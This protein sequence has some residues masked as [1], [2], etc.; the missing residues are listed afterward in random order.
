ML[1]VGIFY[2]IRDNY[3]YWRKL[4]NSIQS[5]LRV[6]PNKEERWQIEEIPY[7]NGRINGVKKR[8]FENGSI[9]EEAQYTRD[10]LDGEVKIYSLD[11]RIIALKYFR[12][13]EE[14][15]KESVGKYREQ[16][17]KEKEEKSKIEYLTEDEMKRLL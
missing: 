12:K 7:K 9:A 8:F 4:E 2:L 16:L 5:L 13:G 1:Y 17:E 10:V 15:E 6:N 3:Y 14:I 11:G